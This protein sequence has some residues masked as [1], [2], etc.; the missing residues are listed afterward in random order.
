MLIITLT[1]YQSLSH[2][3]TFLDKPLL[4]K[5]FNLT[6]KLPILSVHIKKWFIYEKNLCAVGR[7]DQARVIFLC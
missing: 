1:K 6:Q 4:T 5:L 7:L 2:L 3:V